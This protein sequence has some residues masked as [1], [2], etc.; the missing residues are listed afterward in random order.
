MLAALGWLPVSIQ[1]LRSGGDNARRCAG[2]STHSA[3]G[4][5]LP[6]P[7]TASESQR[8][9]RSRRAEEQ[10]LACRSRPASAV[11][12]L[13]SVQQSAPSPDSSARHAVLNP[14]HTH[15]RDV[16]DPSLRP[17]TFRCGGCQTWSCRT[18][19]SWPADRRAVCRPSRQRRSG[20]GHAARGCPP[21]GGPVSDAQ[22]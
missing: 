18:T 9:Q 15:G 2:P 11:A 10:R 4:S 21:A 22:E 7:D 3:H 16:S 6:S 5:P 19:G 13:V 14:A 1:F 17:P 12:R 8:K 20:R